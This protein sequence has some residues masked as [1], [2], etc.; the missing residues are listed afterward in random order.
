MAELTAG[1][2]AEAAGAPQPLGR[3]DS[4]HDMADGDNG[5]A[6]APPGRGPS[7]TTGV[8][9]YVLLSTGISTLL[10]VEYQ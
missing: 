8:F 7:L 2:A 9:V 4:A 1:G 5:A 10:P 6:A 3:Q